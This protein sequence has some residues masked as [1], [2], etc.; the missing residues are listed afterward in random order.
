MRFRDFHR[1]GGYESPLSDDISKKSLGTIAKHPW[2]SPNPGGKSLRSIGA[3]RKKR[4]KMLKIVI[5]LFFGGR[6]YSSP[7]V[8]GSG[9]IH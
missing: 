7:Q 2:D 9:Q 5:L 3:A 8:T 6:P 4:D 1:F